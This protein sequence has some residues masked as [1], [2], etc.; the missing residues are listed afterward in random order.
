MSSA[1][2]P[3][4]LLGWFCLL[5]T[6]LRGFN[7]FPFFPFCTWSPDRFDSLNKDAG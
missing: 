7:L 2:G 3:Y 4:A 5:L 1:N 6:P